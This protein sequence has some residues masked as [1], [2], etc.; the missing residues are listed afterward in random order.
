ME[1]QAL[2]PAEQVD[3]QAPP[4]LV[5]VGDQDTFAP[6][7]GVTTLQARARE[8]GAQ[9]TV[10]EVPFAGH[11]IDGGLINGYAGSQLVRTTSLAW[12][13]EVLEG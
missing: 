4:T 3:A 1:L 9:I 13:T 7:D 12:L 2:S 11:M 5:F 8:V 6:A 10:V